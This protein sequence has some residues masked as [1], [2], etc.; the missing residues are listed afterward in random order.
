MVENT[1]VELPL[2]EKVNAYPTREKHSKNLIQEMKYQITYRYRKWSSS[3]KR[4]HSP[5]KK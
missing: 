2:I 4:H 1:E 3:Q 5:G